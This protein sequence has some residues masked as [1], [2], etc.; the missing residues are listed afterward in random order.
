MPDLVA[1]LDATKE[2]MARLWEIHFQLAFPML[3]GLS[4]FDDFYRDLFGDEDAFQAYRLLQGFE[5]KTLESNQELWA[6]SRK[7]VADPTVRQVFETLAPG[8]IVA[9]AGGERAGPGVPGRA[10]DVPGG[11]RP[12]R[13]HLGPPAARLDR[14]PDVGAPQPEGLRPRSRTATWRPSAPR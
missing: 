11:V 1:H 12:A 6:L 2:R 7:A 8:E 5:N 13:R 10:A 9:G 4:L 3:L 14:G